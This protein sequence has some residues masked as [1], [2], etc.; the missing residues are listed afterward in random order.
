MEYKTKNGGFN[1]L[2][3]NKETSKNQLREIQDNPKLTAEDKSGILH[4]N[5]EHFYGLH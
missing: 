2:L 3:G 4:R 5:A 1:I